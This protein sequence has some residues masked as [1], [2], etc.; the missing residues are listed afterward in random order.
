MD[1]RTVVLGIATLVVSSSV[2]FFAGSHLVED[3]APEKYSKIMEVTVNSEQ[4]VQRVEFENNSFELM[5]ENREKAR[6][7][8][9]KDLDGS[10][11]IELKNLT[12]DGE[13]HGLTRLITFDKTSYRLYF[14]YSDD[15]S[16]KGD[17]Y[18]KLYQIQEI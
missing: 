14:R 5:F 17:G 9:D 3:N 1:Q 12:H 16:I 11:D 10:F 4:E 6:M 8:I 18:L 13:Q 15:D 7:Y 2:V